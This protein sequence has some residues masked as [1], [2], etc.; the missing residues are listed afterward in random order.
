MAQ[1]TPPKILIADGD[2]TSRRIIRRLLNE[3]GFQYVA[4]AK[5]GTEALMQLRS[6]GFGLVISAFHMGPMNGLQ[7][8]QA[9]RADAALQSIPVLIVFA[10]GNDRRSE[11]MI[12]VREAGAS[13]W[14]AM[15][16][17]AVVLRRKLDAL[18]SQA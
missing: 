5:D 6:G 9:M 7:L 10:N 8:L 16:F 13:D 3:T 14:I 17:N 1:T 12:P 18:L 15:P 2:A 11:Y 4:D